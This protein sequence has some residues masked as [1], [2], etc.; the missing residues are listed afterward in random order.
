MYH[1][2]VTSVKNTDVAKK[3]SDE[4]VEDLMSTRYAEK[5]PFISVESQMRGE[6]CHIA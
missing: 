1:D 2:V 4:V 3:F 5:Q 6:G